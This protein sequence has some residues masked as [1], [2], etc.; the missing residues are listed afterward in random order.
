MR[1]P[2]RLSLRERVVGEIVGVRQMIDVR[3]EL[4]RKCFAIRFD[5]AHRNATEAHAMIAARAP[6]EH[7]A[8][9]F[10]AGQMIGHGDFECAVHRFAAGVR[11]EHLAHAG[12]EQLHQLVGQREGER[13]PHLKAR[14]EIQRRCRPTDRV[15]DGGAAVSR[16]HA[17]EPSG[18]VE[19][20]AAVIGLIMH[21][22]GADEQSRSCLERLVGG[23]RH[24]LRIE[25]R[26]E[27]GRNGHLR[28]RVVM[29]ARG[30]RVAVTADT[31]WSAQCVRW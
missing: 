12:G 2:L 10:A 27:R 30:Y 14:R 20:L 24:P 15:D 23:E 6:D 11:E 8:L 13:M 9:R 26:G 22:L 18:P 1:P 19:N 29:S 21:V 4:C 17:P 28:T 25:G 16:V 31:R 3:H 5:A 7:V